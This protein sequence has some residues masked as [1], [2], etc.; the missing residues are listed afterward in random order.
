MDI[1]DTVTVTGSGSDLV[2]FT[3]G[4]KSSLAL[5]ERHGSVC[6][7]GISPAELGEVLRL[8]ERGGLQAKV[9]GQKRL[10]Q[11]ATDRLC[12]W[13]SDL[14][15][16]AKATRAFCSSCE[17]RDLMPVTEINDRTGREVRWWCAQRSGFRQWSV[18][19]D[20]YLRLP[21]DTQDISRIPPGARETQRGAITEADFDFLMGQVPKGRAPGPDRLLFELIGEPG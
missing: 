4:L 8:V 14:A 2:A 13:E 20:D 21:F 1:P 17:G 9:T 12:A 18:H 10:V 7:S 5:T 15:N 3:A 6:I 16:E 11:S 19:E